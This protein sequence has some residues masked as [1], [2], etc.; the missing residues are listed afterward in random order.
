MSL[1]Y[2]Y[3]C[4]SLMSVSKKRD[5]ERLALPFSHKWQKFNKMNK[6]TS[7]GYQ[8]VGVDIITGQINTK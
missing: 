8:S 2:S 3:F 5:T 7:L 1:F 4:C 6:K